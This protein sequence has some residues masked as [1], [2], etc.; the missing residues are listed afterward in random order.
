MQVVQ[1]K[2]ACTRPAPQKLCQVT[3]QLEMA[4]APERAQPEDVV[5]APPEALEQEPLVEHLA[6][7]DHW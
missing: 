6:E 5:A 2:A 3:K 4:A 1:P 7:E